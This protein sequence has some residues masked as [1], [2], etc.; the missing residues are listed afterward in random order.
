VAPDREPLA[1]R[2]T[3]IDNL[4][5]IPPRGRATVLNLAMM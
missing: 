4:R 5:H 2:R 1:R 3:R